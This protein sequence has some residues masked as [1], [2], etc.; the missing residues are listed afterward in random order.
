MG[1]N[2]IRLNWGVGIEQGSHVACCFLKMTWL[3]MAGLLLGLALSGAGVVAMAATPS[4][5]VAQ[6]LQEPVVL[7]PYL[8]VLEDA[9]RT[10]QVQDIVAPSLQGQFSAPHSKGTA[11]GFGF[12][13]S[14][15]WLRVVLSNSSAVPVERIFEIGYASLVKVD[16]YQVVQGQV[17][18]SDFMGTDRPMGNRL[19]PNRHFTTPIQIAPAGVTTIFVRAESHHP[20]II[21]AKLWTPAAFVD[22]ERADYAVQA[23]YF[24]IAF[25][26]FTF[27]FLLFLALRDR[28][29]L[30]YLVWMASLLMTIAIG[31][32][33]AKQFLWPDSV[34]WA[35]YSN[36][37][38]DNWT[39]A[40]LILFVRKMLDT[41][42]F[43]PWPDRTLK[44]LGWFYLLVPF[45]FYLNFR[46]F[47]PPILVLTTC[48]AVLVL[49]ISIRI[50]LQGERAAI[51]FLLAFSTLIISSIVG[52]LWGLDL[53]PTSFLTIYGFQI[54]SAV[55]MILLALALADRFNES[56]RAVLKA[57]SLALEA[58]KGRVEAL[59]QS[60]RV[61]EER[62]LKR[63]AAL[64]DS[65]EQ[66][67][68]T[69]R[70]LVQAEKMASLG[71]LVAGVAHELNTPIGNALTV[72]STLRENAENLERELNNPALRK[73][74]LLQFTQNVIP[75]SE[76]IEKAC[77]QAA[78]LVNSFK[79]VAVDQTSE[80]RR[81]FDL[82]DLVQDICASLS[83]SFRKSAFQ[84]RIEVAPAMGC[85]GY[86]GP[87]GQVISN[88]VQNAALHAFEPGQSGTIVV[89][90]TESGSD[91]H[92]CVEDDGKGIA[93]DVMAKIF[94]PFFTT[95]LGEGGSGLGL[96]IAMNI[97]KGVLGGNLSVRSTVGTGTSFLLIFPRST[98]MVNS[99]ELPAADLNDFHR[100]TGPSV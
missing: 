89:R 68:R 36:A 100:V 50:A 49:G 46:A 88:L 84:L 58:E 17:V 67:T 76:L 43:L 8:Q 97:V 31:T 47:A 28:I 6:T 16:I 54:G 70:E 79:R 30:L 96:A 87:L 83:P 24:G 23:G 59:K 81:K 57:Q 78:A 92:L 12:Q 80:Q 77:N 48:C 9:T 35:S 27:N 66:L 51:I 61:L 29:Y 1:A 37:F 5:D 42:R 20:L 15:I 63:T 26:M 21:P 2:R 93:A 39:V 32:G 33:L 72:A 52:A 55:E 56:R 64:S 73:S 90:A 82:L 3:R 19:L 38:A 7:S 11:V 99:S 41:S 91:I 40:A 44:L 14:A 34:V 98:P 85:E 22:Y 94:D 71:S 25:G 4:L 75:M 62:V 60:E 53:L 69:Q 18:S 13:S 74:T 10:L 65:L 95:R 45:G 86:P